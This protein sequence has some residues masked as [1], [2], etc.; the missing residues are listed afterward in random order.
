MNTDKVVK[1]LFMAF[2]VCAV[3]MG[4]KAYNKHLEHE[5]LV[6]MREEYNDNQKEIDYLESLVE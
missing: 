2:V 4:F 1:Y 6:E 5:K 3:I